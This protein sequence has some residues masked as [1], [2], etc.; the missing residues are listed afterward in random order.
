M[1]QGYVSK[2]DNIYPG[3][4]IRII[5]TKIRFMKSIGYVKC[6]GMNMNAVLSRSD[7]TMYNHNKRNRELMMKQR[8]LLVSGVIFVVV[9]VL[10]SVVLSVTLL[11]TTV[12]AQ[13]QEVYRAKRITSL[14]I[15]EGD[16]LWSIACDYITEEYDDVNDYIY[17]IK[18]TNKLESDIIHT[19]KFIILP[20]YTDG[21]P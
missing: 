13:R 12:T 5:I 16:T 7:M 4:S 21:T 20:Y 18:L 8:R 11:S 2:E 3:G 10:I 17:E 19:G 14:E 15:Q 1:T 6:G 9:A